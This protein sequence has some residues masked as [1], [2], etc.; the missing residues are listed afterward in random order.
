MDKINN[1]QNNA[2]EAAIDEVEPLVP[3]DKKNEFEMVK[4]IA[5]NP[6]KY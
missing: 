4:D 3:Q 1:F 5:L 2:V 6:E